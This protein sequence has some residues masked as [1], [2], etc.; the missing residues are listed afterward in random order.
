MHQKNIQIGLF[1]FL[2]I[3][4][5]TIMGILSMGEP[6]SNM[7]YRGN[8]YQKPKQQVYQLRTTDVD[9]YPRRDRNGEPTHGKD[10]NGSY[11]R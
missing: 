1:I 6:Y 8:K 7:I 11:Y 3:F 4:S 10:A 5:I 9:M 2:G